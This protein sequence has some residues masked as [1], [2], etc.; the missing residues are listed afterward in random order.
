MSLKKQTL[1]SKP[2]CKVTFRI[3]KEMAPDANEAT[4][5]GD[6]ND[7]KEDVTPMQKL[8]SGDFTVTL[9]LSSNQSYQFRYLLNKSEWV[10]EQEADGYVPNAFGEENSVVNTL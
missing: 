7:W 8:K 10:N 6:F 5:V 9:E 2:V 4:V 3:P 1:K